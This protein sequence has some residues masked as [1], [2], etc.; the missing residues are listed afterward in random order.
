MKI[1]GFIPFSLVDFPGRF[2]CIIFTVGCNFRCP[3]C[4]NRDLVF[5]NVEVIPEEK[6]LRWLESKKGKLEG[7]TITGGEPTL[8]PDLPEFIEKVKALG[9]DVKLDTNGSIPEMLREVLPLVDYVAMDLKAGLT[10]ERYAKAT[11]VKDMLERVKE[12]A[13]ILMSSDVP[14][15]FRTT[16]VPGI[17]TEEDI[18][19]IGKFIKGAR[20]W[21]IQQFRPE[22]TTIDPAF[23]QVLP[24]LPST[25]R[26]YAEIARQYVQKVVVRGI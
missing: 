19:S 22:A 15:E 12:S 16:V 8:Q 13:R 11:G 7:C 24:Y 26:K 6:I 10:P 2:S 20:L 1:G 25:V 17:V 21:A 3:F 18:H 5:G 9:F 23:S 14:Y 4:Y